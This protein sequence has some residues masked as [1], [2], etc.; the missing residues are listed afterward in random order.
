MISFH[1]DAT[2][3]CGFAKSSSSMPT[4]LNMPRAAAFSRPSVTSRL[5]G[6]MS[7]TVETEA[8]SSVVCGIV[9]VCGPRMRSPRHGCQILGPIPRWGTR[10]D[11]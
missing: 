6:L 11:G 3:I 4:A 10:Y 5:R 1:D 9:Q 2:P 8:A 7:A